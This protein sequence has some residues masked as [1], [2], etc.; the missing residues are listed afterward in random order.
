M[1]KVLLVLA[2]L[3]GS[4]DVMAETETF[5]NTAVG[6]LP[7]GWISGV[8]GFGSPLWAV[9]PDPTAPSKPNVLKQ[10]GSGTYPWAVKKDAT[11]GDGFV[12]T[13][14]KSIAGKE[15]QAGGV[16]WRFQNGRTY[17]VARANAD[18]D[19]V[20]LYYTTLGIR[21]TIKYV[22]APVPI[23]VWHTLR[24]EFQGKRIRILL[25]GKLY[26]EAEDEHIK[27]PGAVGVW[28]KA[29]SVTAF[30]DFNYGT[31]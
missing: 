7:K 25:N 22:N 21:S 9:A 18:E 23:N 5:D 27:E 4:A 26:I 29:D 15:D 24:A 12:E 3:L 19:N 30:D 1:Q 20:S 11:L 17:Y 6:S 2:A 16:V 14:F 31:R 13:K 8:T 10:S 28:T